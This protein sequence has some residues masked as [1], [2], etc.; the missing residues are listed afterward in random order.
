MIAWW[1]TQ[2]DFPDRRRAAQT[3]A[4]PRKKLSAGA[5]EEAR[6]LIWKHRVRLAHRPGAH[7]RQPAG[8]PRAAVDD[9]VSDGRRDRPAPLGPAAEAG[10][11][12]RRRGDRRRGHLVRQLADPRRR[13]AARDHRHAQGRRSARHA[14]ADP[15]LRLDEER[16]PDLAH[17]DRRRRHPESRRH[18]PRAADGLDP[19]GGHGARHPLL[20]QLAPDGGHHRHPGDVRRRHGDGVQAPAPAR[21]ASAARSTP[22]SPAGSPNRSAASASSR[23]TRRKSARSSSS[24]RAR[25]G[26]SATSR[27]R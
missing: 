26:C 5:W 11:G 12:G 14:P 16:H 19:D 17:H 2:S 10:D 22:R 21:S 15:L 3:D 23:R 1:H 27:S 13:R 9:E 7:G 20:P 25:T 8:R 18:G 24:R 4:R 6:A